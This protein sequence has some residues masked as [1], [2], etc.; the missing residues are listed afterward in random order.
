MLVHT[1]DATFHRNFF[2]GTM[3]DSLCALPLI[4][5]LTSDCFQ[6]AGRES[7]PF[8]SCDCCSQCF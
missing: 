2:E 4:D 5:D 7:P 6:V 3:P 8:V 1:E